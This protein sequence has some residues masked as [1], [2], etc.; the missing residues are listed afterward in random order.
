[1][2]HPVNDEILENLF[3]KWEIIPCL[4]GVG[5]WELS[6]DGECTHETFDKKSEAEQ[7]IQQYVIKEFEEIAQWTIQS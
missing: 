4:N 6:Y 5:Q 3:E 7:A 2:S 1:M